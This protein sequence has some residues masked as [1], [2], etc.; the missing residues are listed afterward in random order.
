MTKFL[1]LTL[2]LTMMLPSIARANYPRCLPIEIYDSRIN[3]M[4][5]HIAR[6]RQLHRRLM[7]LHTRWNENL[8]AMESA[9]TASTVAFVI[10]GIAGT[11]ASFGLGAEV[12]IGGN[13]VRA[14]GS[15]FATTRA[16]TTTLRQLSM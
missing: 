6:N 12:L 14:L 1:A 11:I 3:F 10:A 5:E 13:A 4:Q 16:A 8:Q 15:T 7:R 9:H 2:A